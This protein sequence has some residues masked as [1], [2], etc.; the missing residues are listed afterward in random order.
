VSSSVVSAGSSG[1]EM[2]GVAPRTAQGPVA[3]VQMSP[4]GQ[5]V[6]AHEAHAAEGHEV[7]AGQVVAGSGDPRHGTPDVPSSQQVLTVVAVQ[8]ERRLWAS[9]MSHV[10][11]LYAA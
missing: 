9:Q 5:A 1:S 4:G 10:L 11:P 7:Q 2:S 8:Q 3:V 6:D